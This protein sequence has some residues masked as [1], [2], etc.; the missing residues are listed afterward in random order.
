MKDMKWGIIISLGIILAIVGFYFLT[1]QHPDE[2]TGRTADAKLIKLPLPPKDIPIL[3]ET[4]DNPDASFSE[5]LQAYVNLATSNLKQLEKSPP[6][7]EISSALVRKLIDA[8]DAGKIDSIAWLDAKVPMK[9]N[10][11]PDSNALNRALLA[12]VA[13][14]E[15]ASKNSDDTKV[16]RIGQ[17][18][19]AVGIRLWEGST[20]YYNRMMGFEMYQAG[21][22]LLR[23][24]ADGDTE[25]L[26][27]ISAWDK[28][29]KSAQ[30]MKF[31]KVDRIIRSATPIIQE[32]ATGNKKFRRIG[33]LINLAKKDQD[34]TVRIEATLSLGLAKFNAGTK[35]NENAIK[36]A[37]TQLQSDPDERVAAAAKAAEAYTI[38][39]YRR[40]K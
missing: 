16:K 27:K 2:P 7:V 39:E 9:P 14:A 34:L 35:A 28:W 15:I 21:M 30:E 4:P 22:G 31:I 3:W 17:A 29:Y 23:R 8:K 13:N 40:L 12:V 36:D 38:D 24:K 33:D 19:V 10:A 18:L 6:P 1:V 25:L 26:A 37:I 5:A 20:R 11:E 32:D